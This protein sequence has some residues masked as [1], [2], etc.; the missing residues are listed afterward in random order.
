MCNCDRCKNKIN[1]GVAGS[2]HHIKLK[3]GIKMIT[4]TEEEH[5]IKEKIKHLHHR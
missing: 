3:S 4:D 5:E 1:R 2:E